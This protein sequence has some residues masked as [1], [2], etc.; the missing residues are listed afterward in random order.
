MTDK[1]G[2]VRYPNVAERELIMG[3]PL[4]YTSRC[5]PKSETNPTK[6]MG[7]RLTLLNNSWN[8]TVVVWLL[9]QLFGLLGLRST[10]SLPNSVSN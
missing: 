4:G 9:G 7:E 5:L 6:V 1:K 10:P 8:V 2:N 3:F